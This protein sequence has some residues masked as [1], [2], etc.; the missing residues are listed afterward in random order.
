MTAKQPKVGVTFAGTP[1]NLETIIVTQAC[2]LSKSQKT[3]PVATEGER[4]ELVR[5]WLENNGN[6]FSLRISL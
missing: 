5:Q 1:D 3:L 4:E 6:V 2:R